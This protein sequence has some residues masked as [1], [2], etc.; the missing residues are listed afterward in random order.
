MI[1]GGV[2]GL[3]IHFA[4]KLMTDVLRL[5]NPSEEL[6]GRTL[7]SYREE[8]Q[9]RKDQKDPLG[10]LIRETVEAHETLSPVEDHMRDWVKNEQDRGRSNGMIPNTIL[11]EDDDSSEAGF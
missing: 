3:T 5:D 2:T 4:S 11:E 8:K 7:R 6:R 10:K 9:A 1:V